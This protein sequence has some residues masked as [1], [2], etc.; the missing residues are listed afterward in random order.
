MQPLLHD[1]A[2]TLRAPT[3]VLSG[4]DGQIR[5]NGTQGLLHGDL[6]LVSEAV[7]TVDGHEPAP[8]GF[9]E[10]AADRGTFTGLVRHLGDPGPDPTVWLRRHRRVTASGVAE[11]LE[12]VLSAADAVEC[13]VELALA[14]D[15]APIEV[16]KSGGETSPLVP[17]R[18]DGGVRWESGPVT[19]VVATDGGTTVDGAG[20][21]IRW[22]VRLED[23]VV[24]HWSLTAADPAAPFVPGTAVRLPA[25]VVEADDRRFTALLNR[26]LADLDA[27][28]LAEREHPADVFAGAGAPWFFTLF[29]RDSLWAARLALPLSLELAGGTLRTLARAQGERHDPATGEAPGKIL[30]ERR[31]TGFEVHGM[32]LPARYYG[33]IDATALWVCLLHDA[34]RWGL[35]EAEVRELLPNLRAA[36]FWITGLADTD[37][38][39]FAEYLDESGRGLANQGWKDSGDAVRFADGSIAKPPVALAE[40]QGYQYE[41]AIRAAELLTVLG[42]PVDGLAEWASGLRSRFRERFWVSTADGHFPAL[43]LDGGK[44][45]VDS[46]T[47][48]IGHLLGTGFLD[49]S[50]SDAIGALLLGPSM[51][52]GFGLRTMSSTA[53]GFSPLS[54]HCGSV[55]PHDTA[56]V[57]R[58]LHL[59]GQSARAAELGLQLVHAA[60]AFDNR[61]PELFSGYGA[62]D[63]TAPLPYPASC[64]PQ[65]WAAASAVTL[66]VTF[67]GLHVDVPA[68][69]VTLDPPRPSPVG[70]LRVTGLPLAGGTLDVTIT[71]DGTTT[72]VRLPP[73][74]RLG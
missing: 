34:W 10:P 43:A 21:V 49:E 4:R 36:L 65:A 7:V 22:R 57:V 32:S 67:L 71:A 58:G 35:P 59:A 68:G 33:T 17:V 25:P 73:G 29:G 27:L 52:A 6:R 45:P 5:G 63:V 40:V 24:L 50:E 38:D 8:I 74:L 72:D 70:A 15:F 30:H 31:R 26:S 20:V 13:V 42:E 51:S 64:R 23:Q 41:A 69:V 55:W 66:L 53:G 12:L 56:V 47:S 61:L 9:E 60:G 28:L 16:I 11:E 14:A 19:A 46:L 18:V 48:N 1:L 2:I 39:G 62:A 3:V 54:Y 44:Q 37:G